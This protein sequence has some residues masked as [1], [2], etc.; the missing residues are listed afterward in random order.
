MNRKCVGVLEL[1]KHSYSQ[2]NGQSQSCRQKR[3]SHG[4]QLPS[5]A[6]GMG[7]AHWSDSRQ[8]LGVI[9]QSWVLESQSGCWGSSGLLAKT[10][11]DHLVKIAEKVLGGV[12]NMIMTPPGQDVMGQY[13]SVQVRQVL[14]VSSSPRLCLTLQKFRSP[15]EN[16]K[17]RRRSY[18]S[19]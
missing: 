18:G 13:N 4:K 11:Y 17:E 6:R 16:Y 15:F 3:L 14:R 5:A 12:I 19:I 1:Y 2:C 8:S 10:S 7:A 9:L